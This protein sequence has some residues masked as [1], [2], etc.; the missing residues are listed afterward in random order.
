MM[1]ALPSYC[2]T[3]LVD[4]RQ[5]EVILG[6]GLSRGLVS[7]SALCRKD[8]RLRFAEKKGGPRFVEKIRGLFFVKQEGE[9]CA[10]E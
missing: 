9:D 8:R 1:L 2:C 6:L 5:Q 7:R 3:H 4:A 10:S